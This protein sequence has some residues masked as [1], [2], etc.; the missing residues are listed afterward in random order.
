MGKLSNNVKF[1]TF[2]N[3]L[4]TYSDEESSLSIRDINKYMMEILGITLDRRT[5]YGYI[6]DMRRLGLSV[7]EYDKNKEG[8]YLKSYSL[9]DHEVKTLIDAIRSSK[10]ITKQNKEEIIEKIERLNAIYRGR[11]VTS[12]IYVNNISKTTKEEILINTHKLRTGIKENKKIKFNYL[13]EYGAQRSDEFKETEYVVN[14]ICLILNKED[15]YFISVSDAE[16]EIRT[17]K[18]DNMVDVCVTE[19]DVEKVAEISE[20]FDPGH[21]LEK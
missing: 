8:Y 17:F 3:I 21:M 12:D 16:E 1:Y 5:I 19:D 13:E 6:K 15:Y 9:K 18:V 2:V 20:E 4:S 7:S 11:I 10:F 14:P